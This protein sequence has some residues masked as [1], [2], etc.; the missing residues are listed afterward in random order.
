MVVNAAGNVVTGGTSAASPSFAGVVAMLNQYVVKNGLQS[1]PGLGNINPLL[2]RLAQNTTNVFHDITQGNSMVPCAA[3][4]PDC[5]TGSLGFNA[6]P[7]YD[8]ATGLG[9]IDVFNLFS[10][11]KTSLSGQASAT[12]TTLTTNPGSIT[13]GGTVQLTAT[14]SP[15]LPTGAVTFSTGRTILGS[16]PLVSV[17]GV[18]MATLTVTG[19]Q[20]PVGT[21]TVVASYGGDANFNGST[22]SSTVSVSAPTSGPGGSAVTVAIAPNPARGGQLVEVTLTEEA[23]TGTTITG[24]SINGVDNF[25]RFVT[26]FGSATLPPYGV[27]SAS[28]TSA[29]LTAYP[30]SRLY[31]FTGVD[32]NGRTW[33]QQYNLTVGAPFGLSGI[34]LSSFPAPSATCP[35]QQLLTLQEQ[36]GLGV[37][38]TRLLVNGADLTSQI[39]TLF[40]T[41]RL[42]PLGSL[43]ALIC[44]PQGTTT[45]TVTFEI[46]GV[47]LGGSPVSATATAAFPAGSA[48]APALS[49]SKPLVSLTS[50]SSVSTLGLVL[51]I[52]AARGRSPFSHRTSP[53]NGSRSSRL[54]HRIATVNSTRQ[55]TRA[56]H[57]G[58]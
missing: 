47:D 48:S 36:A 15:G 24:W 41:T 6:G 5:A 4:S 17:A 18:A 21:P 37:Q 29:V 51:R 12:S 13:L 25:Y 20:L 22:G 28:F 46:D 32:A 7:G 43:Q 26:D 53:P 16:A 52:V 3:G 9:S 40:G 31:V 2:Y 57:R 10:E 49:V 33:T 8:Q 56:H 50:Q 58:L 44:V 1:A 14:V 54:W 45:S 39:Q 35:G 23:G 27:L 19:V 55:R 11:W 38:L 42:A 30:S 34:A